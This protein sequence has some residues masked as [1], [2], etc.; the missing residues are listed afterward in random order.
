MNDQ[1]P[2]GQCVERYMSATLRNAH[3]IQAN[4]YDNSS[5][6]HFSHFTV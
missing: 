3:E 4:E 5:A 2:F 6:I 1:Y